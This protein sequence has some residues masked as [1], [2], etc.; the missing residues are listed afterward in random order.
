MA[1]LRFTWYKK[2]DTL[3]SLLQFQSIIRI[4]FLSK[5][6]KEFF[7]LFEAEHFMEN[8]WWLSSFLLQRLLNV[9]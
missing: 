6:R 1:A 7:Q 8:A 4:N 9:H 2:E 3:K 5:Q